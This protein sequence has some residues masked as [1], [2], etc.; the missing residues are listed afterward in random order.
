MTLIVDDGVSLPVEDCDGVDAAVL[1][2]VP[3]PEMV[4][5]GVIL[6]VTVVDAVQESDP[7]ED[8]LAPEVN[9]EVGVFENDLE[10]L[11][12]DDGVYGGVPLDEGVIVTVGD[13]L[14]DKEL[15]V[16]DVPVLLD[17]K[18]ALAPSESEGGGVPDNE[19]LNVIVEEGVNDEVPVGVGVDAPV[20]DTEAVIE[21]LLLP[22][23][24]G[25]EVTE[26]VPDCVEVPL[27]LAPCERV[28]VGDIEV[29]VERLVVDDEL[30]EPVGD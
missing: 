8:G 29:V 14:N 9:D 26:E 25:L 1:E 30:S 28:V 18:D 22:V 13:A 19:E 3:V 4:G 24:V 2:L 16:L 17:V 15:V 10:R 20:G 5:D 12:V 7:V 27:A 23:I 6:A 21:A 11:N